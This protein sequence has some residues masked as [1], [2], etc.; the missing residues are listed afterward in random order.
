[1]KNIDQFLDKTSNKKILFVFPHP[2]DEVVMSGGLIQ[3]ALGK[4]FEVT[5]LTLTE[6]NMGKIYVNGRGRSVVEIRREE[7]AKAM[8]ILGVYDWVMWK[9][10]DG[11]LRKRSIWRERLKKFID[12]TKPGTVVTYDLSGTTGHPDHISLSLELLRKFKK[13]QDFKLLWVSFGDKRRNLMVDPKVGKY[14]VEP[15]YILNLSF[16]DAF[17]KWKSAFSHKS[18]RLVGYLKFSWWVLVFTAREEWYVEVRQVK[19]YRY[20]FPKFKI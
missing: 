1:M 9:F 19:K 12:E 7:M 6:G 17:R 20:K 8:S 10:E 13:E 15:E 5:V 14:L 16:W 4:G 2:D 11:R 18:Q 3:K